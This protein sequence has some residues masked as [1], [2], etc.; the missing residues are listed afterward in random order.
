[1]TDKKNLY[2][3]SIYPH[4]WLAILTIA[5]VMGILT[6]IA[7]TSLFRPL[8]TNQSPHYIVDQTIIV[9]VEGACEFPGRYECRKGDKVEEV[10]EKAKP[11]PGA[12]MARYKP[13]A[14][15]RDG[16]IIRFKAPRVKSSAPKKKKIRD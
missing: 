12:V 14:K 9:F 5:A 2:S 15:L 6:L 7:Q 8:P 13:E 10:L 1:M 4:E 16:Q 3:T 11:F